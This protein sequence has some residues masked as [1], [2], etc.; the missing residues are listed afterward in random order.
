MKRN[1]VLS[2]D[3]TVFI[4]AQCTPVAADLHRMQDHAS[5]DDQ[6]LGGD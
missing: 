2:D 4:C 6:S 5:V 1:G 3:G